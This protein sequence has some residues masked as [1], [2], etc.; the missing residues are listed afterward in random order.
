MTKHTTPYH[1]NETD[2]T[3]G[4]AHLGRQYLMQ[5][6]RVVAQSHTRVGRALVDVDVF[7]DVHH[8][9]SLRVYLDQHLLTA[10][11]QDIEDT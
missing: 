9:L 3:Q 7:V 6:V 8:V 4:F 2:N 10:R 5:D 1:T 11:T